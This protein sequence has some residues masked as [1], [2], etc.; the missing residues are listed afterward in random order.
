MGSEGRGGKGSDMK[1]SW[2]RAKWRAKAGM[3]LAFVLAFATMTAWPHGEK[4]H[5][6]ASLIPVGTILPV[7]LEHTLSAEEAKAGQEIEAEI[8]QDVPLSSH[9]RIKAQSKVHGAVVSVAKAAG[10][11]GVDVS[12][13]FDKIEY[14]K[15]MIPMITS[16]RAMASYRAVRGA[17]TPLAGAD[18]GT[19]AGW[20]DTV[21]I[22]GDIRFGDGFSG[23]DAFS[24]L[25]N[26]NSLSLLFLVVEPSSYR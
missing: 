20:G 11:E 22:G 25:P 5:V 24:I 15:K 6:T 1:R 14:D 18:S 16:L 4:A 17:Q 9:E 19:P 26:F 10:G 7:R 13:R 3:T 23:L 21:Q 8:T 2:S 12:L